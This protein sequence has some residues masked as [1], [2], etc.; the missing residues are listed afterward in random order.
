MGYWRFIV[1]EI[2]TLIDAEDTKT[3]HVEAL[4][5]FK[6]RLEEKLMRGVRL[7]LHGEQFGKWTVV[8]PAENLNRKTRWICRCECGKERKVLTENL[9]NG[10]SNSCGCAGRRAR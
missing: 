1:S 8:S 7:E 5:W 10:L 9:M 4:E 2:D 3:S 6:E